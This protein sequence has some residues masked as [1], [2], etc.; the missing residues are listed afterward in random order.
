MTK[1]IPFSQNHI[2]PA[3]KLL[4]ARHKQ[5]RSHQALLPSEFEQIDCARKAIQFILDKDNTSGFVAI[6]NDEIVSYML[7]TLI[8]EDYLGDKSQGWVY[9][10]SYA[11][12]DT[13]LL[14]DLYALI[15]EH[16][17]KQ[18]CYDHFVH[19]SANNHALQDAW[20]SLSFGREQAHGGLHFDKANFREVDQQGI[21]IRE[22]T[23][24]DEV[25][26]R[27]M[28]QW[29]SRYQVWTP[30][31]APVTLDYLTQQTESFATL[32]SDDDATSFLAFKDDELL[33]Y[34][35]YYDVEDDMG[36]M[37]HARGST[38]LVVAATHP[39]MKGQ[40]IGRILTQHAFRAMQ[41][42]GYKI[43]VTDWRTANRASSRFWVKM[44]FVPTHYRL[45]RRLDDRISTIY[46]ELY[47]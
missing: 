11:F 20:F 22:A 19:V 25:Y 41:Q 9:L 7:G 31:F 34:Q 29:I 14:T 43:C 5:D 6:Q 35:V 37:M 28:S 36:D 33:G 21:T 38:E 47:P 10:P 42:G 17:V 27:Q 23:A 16:W 26:F 15:A 3:A 44:G 4:A 24:H 8:K 46:E 30:T 40:G 13:G 45:V 12:T 32:T 2:E 39:K 1:I 18:G